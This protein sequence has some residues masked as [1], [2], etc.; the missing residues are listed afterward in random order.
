[1]GEF[2]MAHQ[3]CEGEWFFSPSSPGVMKGKRTG[4]RMRGM[5]FSSPNP[6]NIG[7]TMRKSLTIALA[8][9]LLAGAVPAVA[10]INGNWAGTGKGACSPPPVGPNDFAIYAWQSWKGVIE[11][12]AF[13]GKWEDKSGNYGNFKGEIIWVSQTE[14]YA[15]GRWTWIYATPDQI[16]EYDMGEFS[17]KF[18][19]F[20]VETPY[21][22]GKWHSKYSNEGGSMKGR[23]IWTD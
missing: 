22:W 12:G 3:R 23:M 19:H 21:C 14:A 17:M 16:K 5:S 20:P 1:M 8:V 10:Q 13:Y 9:I 11:G 6:K 2:S 18:V 7:A 15:E 4:D